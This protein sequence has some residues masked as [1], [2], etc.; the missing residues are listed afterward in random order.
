MIDDDVTKKSGIYD[1]VL[2][3]DEKKLSIREF[4]LQMKQSAYEKQKGICPICCKH[5]ELKEMEADHIT[6]WSQGGRTIASNCQ[7]LCKEDNRRKS[8]K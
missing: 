8:N 4:T 2:S 6:P 7:M 1:Y 5:F 3:G